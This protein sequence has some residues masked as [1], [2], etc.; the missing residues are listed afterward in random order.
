M[1]LS[2][3]K[4]TTETLELHLPMS[5]FL[6]QRTRKRLRPMSTL[7]V[8]PSCPARQSPHPPGQEKTG[9]SCVPSP[10]YVASLS[11]MMKFPNC[12]SVCTMSLL[13]LS[14]LTDSFQLLHSV[15]VSLPSKPRVLERNLGPLRSLSR[16]KTSIRRTRFRGLRGRWPNV[17]RPLQR[18]KN[19]NP[20]QQSSRRLNREGFDLSF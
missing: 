17:L 18:E 12:V 4:D 3:T 15:S 11:N 14:T 2:C 7:K 16:F 9:K 19:W 13:P 10:R 6:V 20:N 5:F 1:H 8:V